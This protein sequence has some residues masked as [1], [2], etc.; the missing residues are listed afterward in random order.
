[1]DFL[2]EY[3]LAIL[4]RKESKEEITETKKCMKCLRRVKVA[5]YS[6]PHCGSLGFIYNT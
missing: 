5:Y 1:M 2:K 3:F 6:C 4:L